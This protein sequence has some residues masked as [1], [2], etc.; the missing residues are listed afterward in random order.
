[1]GRRLRSRPPGPVCDSWWHWAGRR[2]LTSWGAAHSSEGQQQQQCLSAVQWAVMWF[3]SLTPETKLR[4]G[5]CSPC[6]TSEETEARG[7]QMSWS[8]SQSKWPSQVWPVS[9]SRAVVFHGP[10]WTL[11]KIVEF[12]VLLSDCYRGKCNF[13][14]VLWKKFWKILIY[15][16]ILREE[17]VKLVWRVSCALI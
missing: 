4:E 15:F 9:D 5:Y 1:M 10:Y 13:F 6:F 14:L 3:I 17:M 16:P 11:C 7:G 8:K 2:R 12:S